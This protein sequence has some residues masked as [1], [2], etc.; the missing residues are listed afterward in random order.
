MTLGATTTGAATSGAPT[1]TPTRTCAATGDDV[2][3]RAPTAIAQT[4]AGRIH[5]V[6]NPPSA[7]DTAVYDVATTCATCHKRCHTTIVELA[8]AVCC[9]ESGPRPRR[10]QSYR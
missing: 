10:R 8:D 3:S 9:A 5:L 6:M 4:A 7:T 1:N 2:S